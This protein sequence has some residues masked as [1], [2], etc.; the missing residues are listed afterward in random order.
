[1]KGHSQT[2]RGFPLSLDEPSALIV[3]GARGFRG[4][5]GRLIFRYGPILLVFY[6]IFPQLGRRG[7]AIPLPAIRCHDYQIVADAM[8]QLRCD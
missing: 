6:V 4:K 2:I 1:M 8:L 5:F 3:L 7:L